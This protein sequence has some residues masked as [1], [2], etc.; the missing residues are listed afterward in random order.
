MSTAEIANELADLCRANKNLEAIEKFYSDHITSVESMSAP[1]MPAEMKGLA[2][3]R[4][5][6]QWWLEN[7]E[8]HRSSVNGPFIG[9]NQFAIEFDYDVTQKATGKRVQMKEMALYKVEGGKIV[10]EHFY[11]P[12]GGQ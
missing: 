10:H 4:G 7:H 8:V 6:N 5:K 12:G 2:A 1:G 11:Y 9:D 3:V